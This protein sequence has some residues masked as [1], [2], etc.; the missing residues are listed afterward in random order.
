MRDMLQYKSSC[1]KITDLL[2]HLAFIFCGILVVGQSWLWANLGLPTVHVCLSCV[3]HGLF[4]VCLDRNR[5][6]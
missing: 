4:C 3:C 2:A 6:L 5:T 1:Q